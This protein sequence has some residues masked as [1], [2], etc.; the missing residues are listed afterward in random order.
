MSQLAK[1]FVMKAEKLRCDGKGTTNQELVRRAH[2]KTATPSQAFLIEARH[3]GFPSTASLSRR[4]PPV[5]GQGV[6]EGL[7]CIPPSGTSSVR[8]GVG[9]W[10]SSVLH[11]FSRECPCWNIAPYGRL[12]RPPAYIHECA[13]VGSRLISYVCV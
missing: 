3:P 1:V 11:T 5:Y 12:P 2:K 9:A 8:L 13:H 7:V 10:L 6:H 4:L